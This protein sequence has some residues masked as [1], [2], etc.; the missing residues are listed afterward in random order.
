MKL[1][2][3]QTI[4]R[5]KVALKQASMSHEE[6][7]WQVEFAELTL[8]V[9]AGEGGSQARVLVQGVAGSEQ[10]VAQPPVAD[11]SVRYEH[12]FT[13][14]KAPFRGAADV[15]EWRRSR[16]LSRMVEVELEAVNA[17]KRKGQAALVTRVELEWSLI[18]HPDG[19]VMVVTP[20]E[21]ALGNQWH[22]LKLYFTN[23]ETA[24]R[25]DS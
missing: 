23:M 19:E 3:M 12:V 21:K 5:V 4:K 16:R 24:S 11:Q 2:A 22:S 20:E 18:V 17:Q 6:L 10:G 14:M 1:T 15:W 9:H 13:P 25:S 8:W 7:A